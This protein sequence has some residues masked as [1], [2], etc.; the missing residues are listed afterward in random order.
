MRKKGI[1]TA[2][3]VLLVVAVAVYA[4][5][6]ISHDKVLVNYMQRAGIPDS[7]IGEILVMPQ[8]PLLSGPGNDLIGSQV[9][10]NP[11]LTK[12]VVFHFNGKGCYTAETIFDYTDNGRKK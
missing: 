1:I 8:L 3:V 10:V 11:E 2:V 9:Y 5:N 7:A 12:I 6:G 4:S